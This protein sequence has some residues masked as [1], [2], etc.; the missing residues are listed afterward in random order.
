MRVMGFDYISYRRNKRTGKYKLS[1]RL[2]EMIGAI[3]HFTNNE[4]ESILD[5]GAADGYMM[6]QYLRH[7][8]VDAYRC[9]GIEPSLEFI[10]SNI[11]GYC[12]LIQAVGENLPFRDGVFSVITA[13]SVLDHMKDPLLFIKEARRV[14]RQN[15]ILVISLAHPFYDKL[16]IRLKFKED[17]HVFHFTERQL[18]ELLEKNGFT[19]MEV[20]RFALPFF[21]VFFE[22]VIE[23]ILNAVNLKWCMF[24]IRIVA[25]AKWKN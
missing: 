11:S 14:L 12:P 1:K 18:V 25:R 8:S 17:D 24:Y 7:L 3:R 10:K 19:V 23:N 15:G 22:N 6:H 20:S 9:V 21:G 2:S 16:A 13:S 4:N 5:V